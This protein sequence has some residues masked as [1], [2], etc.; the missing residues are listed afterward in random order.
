M[1]K[2]CRSCHS[3]KLTEIL[4]LG[5]QYLSDFTTKGDP[6]PESHPLDL[7]MCSE[8]SLVQLRHTV[9]TSSLYNDHYGYYSGISNT[10]KAD[11]KN[12]V[13]RALYHMDGKLREGDIVIDIGSNDATLLKNYPEGFIK[14]GFDPVSK[15]L[16]FYDKKNLYLVNDFF[17][18][19]AY[20]SKIKRKAKIIT[21]VSMFYDLDNPN[22][23]V[24]GLRECLDEDGLIIIQQNYVGGMIQQ[25]AF[26]NIVHEHL[27]YYSL[28]SMERLLQRHGLEVVDV[29]LNDINGGSFRTYIKHMNRV[30]QMRV[31][32]QNMR[33]AKR[34]TYM[35]YGMKVKQLS[36]KLHAF[37]KGEVDNGKKIYVYGASTRGN[38]LLQAAGLDNTLIKAA[39]ERNPVKFGKQ[40]AS[41]EIPIISEEQARKEKPDYFLVLPWFFSKEIIEREKKF[42][43]DG[44]SL[45]FPLP[46]VYVVNKHNYPNGQT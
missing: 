44:G 14:I 27:E 28:Y 4:S 3:T 33:L 7:I 32:E 34:E 18:P 21:S 37:V 35:L 5:D 1:I 25:H 45:L 39:V 43:M 15:F 30:R 26:D 36:N 2:N 13:D 24:A 23:F 19:K 41:L 6:K 22:E 40:I 20:L 38:T 9:P 42:V 10:I 17:N 8:C 11:L 16:K 31:M 29:E 12:I 46:D